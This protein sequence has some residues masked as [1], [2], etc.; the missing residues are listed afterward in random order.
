[1]PITTSQLDVAVLLSIRD[2]LRLATPEPKILRIIGEESKRKG[3]DKLSSREI[4][5]EIKAVRTAKRERR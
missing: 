2:Y 4:D 3:T 1:M 5:Q